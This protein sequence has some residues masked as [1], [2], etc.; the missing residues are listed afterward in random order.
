MSSSLNPNQARN[1]QT[2]LNE[3]GCSYAPT[4]NVE[5]A[6]MSLADGQ[7]PI[8]VMRHYQVNVVSHGHPDSHEIEAFRRGFIQV[9]GYCP[10]TLV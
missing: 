8:D 9:L 7:F 2:V 10:K 1:L 6:L 5:L 4:V 3:V